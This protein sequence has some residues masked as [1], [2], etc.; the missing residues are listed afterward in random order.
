MSYSHGFISCLI[1]RFIATVLL[2]FLKLTDSIFHALDTNLSLITF[3]LTHQTTALI[4]HF[5][6]HFFFLYTLMLLTSICQLVYSCF[7]ISYSFCI[8]CSYNIS[9]QLHIKEETYAVWYD[10][11]TSTTNPMSRTSASENQLENILVNI[12]LLSI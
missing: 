12:F 4:N 2:L 7:Q 8:V 6:S 9:V 10:H 3:S 1:P 5:F 11:S